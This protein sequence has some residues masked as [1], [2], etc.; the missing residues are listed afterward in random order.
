MAAAAYVQSRAD[1]VPTHWI[2]NEEIRKRFWAFAGSIG[3]DDESVHKALN[4]EHVNE[5]PGTMEQVKIA[6]EAWAKNI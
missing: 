3:L 6:M 2:E 1:N 5:F 4:V